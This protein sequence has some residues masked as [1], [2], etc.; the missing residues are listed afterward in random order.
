MT[1]RDAGTIDLA[2]V[3]PLR[4]LREVAVYRAAAVNLGLPHRLP[5]ESLTVEATAADLGSLAGHPTLWSLT[6][7]ALAAPVSIEPLATLPALADLDLSTVEVT[8]L[9]RVAAL[10]GLRILT[11]HR[12]QWQHLR[13]RDALPA[14]LAAA[15]L[16]SGAALVEAVDWTGW[17]DTSRPARPV[18]PPIRQG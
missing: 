1:L 14:G 12:R 11:L 17:L 3:A 5:V 10:P 18:A 15:V 6:V 2:E 7:K 13:D 16:S 4:N 9:E 8:D